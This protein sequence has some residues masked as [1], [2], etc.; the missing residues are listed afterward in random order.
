MIYILHYMVDDRN[1]ILDTRQAM[2]DS[3]YSIFDRRFVAGMV[4]PNEVNTHVCYKRKNNV[5]ASN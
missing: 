5:V 2:L 3:R 1:S 4:R